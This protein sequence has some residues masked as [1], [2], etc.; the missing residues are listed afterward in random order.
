MGLPIEMAPLY[1]QGLETYETYHLWLLK[2]KIN[3]IPS[4]N[5]IQIFLSWGWL[6][7]RCI[8]GLEAYETYHFWLKLIFASKNTFRPVILFRFFLSWDWLVYRFFYLHTGMKC[9]IFG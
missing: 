2:V 4:C 6:V 9:A 8:Q 3:I 5:F 1:I 7:Y